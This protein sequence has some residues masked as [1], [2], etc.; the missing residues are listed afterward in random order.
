MKRSPLRRVSS[1]QAATNR[2][3][4]KLQPPP[5][6]VCEAGSPVCTRVGVEWH[7][8]RKRSAG[9]TTTDRVNLVWVCRLCNGWVED[10]PVAAE[11]AGLVIREGHPDW[12]VCGK[13]RPP[14]P[15]GQ[16][17]RSHH[18][19]DKGTL[20]STLCAEPD[21]YHPAG[22]NDGTTSHRETGGMTGGLPECR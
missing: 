9:G 15:E 7:E 6:R 19:T 3:R 20:R 13:K 4:A 21:G 22:S 2:V 14:Q 1:R 8:R 18:H 16:G 17:G 11:Q 10:N 12:V 5:S